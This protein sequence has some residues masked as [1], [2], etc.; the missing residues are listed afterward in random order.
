MKII[1][2]TIVKILMKP[3]GVGFDQL[4]QALSTSNALMRN[5]APR[6]LTKTAKIS[7]V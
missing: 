5:A 4:D 2:V 1:P 3:A 7:A 6:I